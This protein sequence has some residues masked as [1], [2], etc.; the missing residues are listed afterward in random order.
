[1][2][3]NKLKPG[4]TEDFVASLL[5]K[6]KKYG[7]TSADVVMAEGRELSATL[8]GGKIDTIERSENS[9]FGLR[10]FVG[11]QSAIISSSKFD[12]A[13]VL[14][15]RAVS[16]AKQA[17]AD[18]YASLAAKDQLAT[19]F[20]DLDVFDAK[21]P[22]PSELINLATETEA[23]AL[24]QKGITNSDGADSGFGSYI[25]T[26]ATS[27][28]FY[29]THNSTRFSLSVSVLAGSGEGME[30]DYDFS[31]SR[32]FADLRSPEAIAKYAAERTIKRL[33]PRKV[34]SG[35]YPIIF[36]PRISNDIVS[37]LATGINGSSV[38]RGTSYLKSKMG[39]QLFSSN[40]TITDDPHIVRGM[41]SKPFDAEGVRNEKINVIE[42]GVLKT[43]L[44]DTRSANQLKT[45]TNGRAARGAGSPPSPSCTNLYMAAGKLSPEELIKD[46]KQGFYVTETSGMGV[47]YTNGDYSVGASGFWIE[48]G[49]ITY[50]VNEV[51][52]A[53]NLLDMF[54]NLI[55]A[56]DLVFTYS[57][58]APTIRLEGMTVAGL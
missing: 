13:D 5:E 23:I 29:H 8:H 55:P 39:E 35:V 57:I 41:A 1:M 9:G 19:K 42:N 34:K 37:D 14:A 43:W 21:E 53:G 28:G 56:N 52:L 30:R 38:A 17:P 54:K 24:A 22:E 20:I 46:I 4:S 16:M 49:E 12:D 7:A 2:P 33:N 40:I 27:S 47:N 44:L 36:E 51:T 26:L 15:E 50:P 10:A 58:N 45:K 25:T 11:S 18:E 32:H 6:A 48:N 31:S 3:E